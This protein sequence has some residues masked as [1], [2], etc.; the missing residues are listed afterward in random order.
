MADE[1][2]LAP[3]LSVRDA[4]RAVEFYAAAFGAVESYRLDGADGRVV[5]AQ[6]SVGAA[7][8]WV[9][10]EPDAAAG[11]ARPVRMILSVPDPDAAF[12]RAVAAGA[13]VVFPVGEEHGFRTGRLTDPFGHDWETSRRLG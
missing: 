1:V 12:G 5:V 3:W 8:F 13:T 2:S 9:Q 4:A 6:L 7:V 10:D 11:G